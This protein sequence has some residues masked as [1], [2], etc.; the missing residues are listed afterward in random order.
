[1]GKTLEGFHAQRR[2]ARDELRAFEQRFGVLLQE[3]NGKEVPGHDVRLTPENVEELQRL[4]EE[5]RRLADAYRTPQKDERGRQTSD[6]LGLRA[7][8]QAVADRDVG[9]RK[10]T[11]HVAYP[12]YTAATNAPQW[13]SK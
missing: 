7:R 2:T 4:L 3:M 1:M 6:E 5:E 13:V 9:C 12:C 8:E 11:K 10:R